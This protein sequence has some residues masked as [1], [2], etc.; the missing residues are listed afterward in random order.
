MI[1][2][3]IRWGGTAGF[4]GN[5]VIFAQENESP[6]NTNIDVVDFLQFGVL[7]LMFFLAMIGKV[8]WEREVTERDAQ[9]VELK[10]ALVKKD[11]VIDA[12]RGKF[13]FEYT[14]LLRDALEVIPPLLRRTRK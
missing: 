1:Y 7:G 3:L 12:Y 4:T 11:E 14:P 10:A 6:L 8:R 5:A 13:E 2:R 9:I